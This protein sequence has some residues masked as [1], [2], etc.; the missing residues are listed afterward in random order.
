VYETLEGKPDSVPDVF[1][2]RRAKGSIAFRYYELTEVLALIDQ[3]RAEGWHLRTA[4]DDEDA[5]KMFD[6]DL[7]QAARRRITK[8]ARA[9]EKRFETEDDEGD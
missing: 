1:D 7:I 5:D 8:K 4:S 9:I 2:T 3:A 6:W